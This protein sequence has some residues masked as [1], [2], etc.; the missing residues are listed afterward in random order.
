MTIYLTELTNDKSYFPSLD[1]ALKDPD[2]L[3]AIGGDLSPE[4]IVSAYRQGIFPWFSDGDPILWWSPSKRAVIQPTDCHISK[5]MK[6]L[7]RKN[8]FTVTVN[9]AFSDV[10]D[11]CAQPRKSQAETWICAAMITAYNKLH[12]LGYAHSIEVWKEEQLVG[13]LY[14]M[15][16]GKFFCGESMFSIENNSSKIAFIALNQHLS[17]F[18]NTYIDCQMQTS[19]LSSLGVKE[20]T[21]EK[22]IQYLHTAKEQSLTEHCWTPQNIVLTTL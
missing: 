2:G 9:H 10:I 12:Q 3:L 13:G 18:E 19:H 6:R 7:I 1:S 17:Q 21:R 15:S 8:T 14:G 22:F 11:A 20:I 5:S 16:I 4:R